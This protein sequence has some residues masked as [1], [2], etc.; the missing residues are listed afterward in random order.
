MKYPGLPKWPALL[1]QGE[2][3]TREQA[4]EI[5]LRTADPYFGTN[6]HEHR[7]RL[8]DIMGVCYDEH[9]IATHLQGEDQDTLPKPRSW[10]PVCRAGAKIGSLSLEFNY[11]HN[12]NVVSCHIIGPH[13]WCSWDGRI[14]ANTFNIGKWP[15]VEE[16]QSD[17]EII[18]EAFPYLN[19]KCQLLDDERDD[20]LK[21]LVEYTVS[22]GKVRVDTNPDDLLMEIGPL[23]CRNINDVSSEVGI[24]LERF[25]VIWSRLEETTHGNL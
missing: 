11:L 25:G 15:S 14:H 22:E 12:Y 16:V 21:P 2:D 9:G 5:N 19:L 24:S 13:G 10:D 4:E 6:H 8:Y 20:A 1:V 23:V 3:V 18:A 17:W 7:R